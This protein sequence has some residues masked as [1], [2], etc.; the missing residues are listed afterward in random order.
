MRLVSLVLL[1]SVQLASAETLTLEQYLE[2]VKSHNP[3][4]RAAIENI[5]SMQ[6]RLN[7]A[8]I[9]ITPEGYAGYFLSDDKK[10]TSVP[11]F[12][13]TETRIEQL[14]LGVRD[15]TDFG[16]GANLFF[17]QQRTDIVNVLPL[18]LP[19]ANY[20][21][22]NLNLQLTQSLWRNG[23]G[24]STRAQVEVNKANADASLLQY[25][26]QLKNILLNAQN[27]YWA[28]VSLN[29]IVRL[30]EENVGRALKLRDYMNNRTKLKLYDDT[31]F[32]QAEASYQ[33]RQL[34]LQSS[35][36][37][38]SVST[39]QFNTLRGID[40]DDTIDLVNLPGEEVMV[41]SKPSGHMTREDF[42][43]LRA[44]ARANAAQA[45]G[46][47]SQLNP[48]LDM[49]ANVATN[50]RDGL[51][52]TAFQQAETTQYPTWSVGITFSVPLDFGLVRDLRR[53][54]KSASAAAN[55]ADAQAR[56]SEVRAWD[57]LTKQMREAQG[58]YARALSVEKIET[59][60]VKR[61]HRR[62]LDGR[63]TT[64]EALNIEQNLALAQIQRVRSQLTFLQV[65][66]A[67]KTFEAK[68]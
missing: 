57:D 52:N 19:V 22:T 20:M 53:G 41:E 27:A 48:Q 59:D 15:Q 24:E 39:R 23:F 33:S 9:P 1:L 50:G 3:D 5:A 25:K 2:Q 32:M 17:Q 13:G 54:Y 31:D 36:D 12:M 26:F 56:F 18:Y 55:D 40:S 14:R 11:F 37:D 42:E 34:E 4:A 35:L 7:E 49:Q 61:E 6:S 16:L 29:Q 38:R 44:Q 58:R 21:E 68:Q 8:D 67:V 47:A 46:A 30:Q 63:T 65:R 64:F 66:N 45:R 28:V 62:L 60:L 10:P 51:A 43:M